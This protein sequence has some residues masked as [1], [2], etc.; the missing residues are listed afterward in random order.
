MEV[1]TI[2]LLNDIELAY[3]TATSFPMDVMAAHEQVR[4][5]LP[6]VVGRNFYGISRLDRGNIVYK[7]GAELLPTDGQNVLA[8]SRM[9]LKKGNYCSIAI[10]NFMDNMPAI[11][12]AFQL[13]LTQPGLDPNGFCLEWYYNDT[14]VLCMVPL[15]D[16]I[17]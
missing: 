2:E 8:G 7:A 17:S 5:A 16:N 1:K 13:L 11:G 12:R 6:E 15:T 10:E 14:D 3:V 4:A 9:T